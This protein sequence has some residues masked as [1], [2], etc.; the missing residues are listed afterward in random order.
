MDE[1]ISIEF[2]Q[3]AYKRILQYQEIAGATTVQNAVLNAI[4]LAYDRADCPVKCKD[5]KNQE[6]YGRN[7]EIVCALTGEQHKPDWFCADG[8]L[9]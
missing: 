5:C 8:E 7:G 4:S 6:C 3:D 1:K 2:T 9:I